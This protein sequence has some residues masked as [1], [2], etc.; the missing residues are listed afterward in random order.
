MYK[1][2]VWVEEQS[3]GPTIKRQPATH[4]ASGA[5]V[6]GGKKSLAMVR[7]DNP[8]PEPLYKNTTARGEIVITCGKPGSRKSTL[9]AGLFLDALK[10]D[11]DLVCAWFSSDATKAKQRDIISSAGF[12][13]SNKNIAFYDWRGTDTVVLDDE[14]LELTIQSAKE[15]MQ[16]LDVIILDSVA[17]VLIQCGNAFLGNDVDVNLNLHSHATKAMSWL[18]SLAKKYNVVIEGLTHPAKSSLTDLPFHGSFAQHTDM[19]RHTYSR[20]HFE[21]LSLI[22]I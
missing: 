2:Q 7:H 20:T 12:D 17:D 19:T 14:V 10:T 11:P 6:V 3:K 5:V 4:P 1:R 16:R 13:W 21:H 8:N 9:V 22:H 18:V 15:E